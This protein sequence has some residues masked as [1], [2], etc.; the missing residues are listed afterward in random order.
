MKKILFFIISLLFFAEVSAQNNKLN[1][2]SGDTAKIVFGIDTLVKKIAGDSI[3]YQ[4]ITAELDPNVYRC[5]Y[6]KDKD[7]KI[8]HA[9][10]TSDTSKITAEWYFDNNNLIYSEQNWWNMSDHKSTLTTKMY[11]S[12]ENLVAYISSSHG[13]YDPSSDD[14]RELA[15]GLK[16]YAKELKARFPK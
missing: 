8:V 13:V 12:N 15:V 2:V 11:L 7:L 9:D 3:S 1:F 10:F 14:F 4:R 6:L 16:E 5:F